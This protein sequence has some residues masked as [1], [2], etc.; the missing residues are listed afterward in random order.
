VTALEIT[1]A[2]ITAL[3]IWL[4]TRE[5]VWYFPTG[6]VS[7]VMYTWIFVQARLYAESG[8]QVICL[9]LML[10]GWYEWLFGGE[11]HTQLRVSR[12]PLWGWVV[13]MVSGLALA[14]ATAL[15]QHRY[16][17]NPSPVIDSS[18]FAFSIVTQWMTA[19]KWLENWVLWII[20][21]VVSVYLYIV[22]HL[23]PTAALYVVLLVL[24]FVGYREWKKSLVSA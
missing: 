1:A 24:A 18:I 20:I 15:V 17:N 7:L 6:I 2:L 3:S 14:A 5:N 8:L 19:R 16:T 12:T 21:N 10:Y 23:Y 9:G 4:A 22:R 13:A 11:R